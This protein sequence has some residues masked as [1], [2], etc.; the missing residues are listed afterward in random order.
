MQVLHQGTLLGLHTYNTT[1]ATRATVVK[2]AGIA[3]ACWLVEL[4]GK[5]RRQKLEMGIW[6]WAVWGCHWEKNGPLATVIIV[7]LLLLNQKQMKP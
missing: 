2:E 3:R 6:S 1:F 4:T 5:R 7:N